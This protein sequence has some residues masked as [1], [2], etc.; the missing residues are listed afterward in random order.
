MT[1]RRKAWIPSNREVFCHEPDRQYKIMKNSY[2]IFYSVL[3]SIFLKSTNFINVQHFLLPPKV[4][5]GNN[6][7]NKRKWLNSDELN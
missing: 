3:K 7:E 5:F 6:I 4:W 2:S 1:L